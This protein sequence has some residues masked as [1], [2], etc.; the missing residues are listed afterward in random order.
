MP[1]SYPAS[2]LHGLFDMRRVL[3]FTFTNGPS[4]CLGRNT[5]VRLCFSQGRGRSPSNGNGTPMFTSTKVLT[6]L[7][8]AVFFLQMRFPSITKAGWKV[9][10]VA[11]CLIFDTQMQKQKRLCFE[12]SL[13]DGA[14]HCRCL[15][16]LHCRCVRL[17]EPALVLG[18]SQTQLRV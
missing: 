16:G 5:P 15:R 10:R 18:T 13:T 6:A 3:F 17:E 8:V 7:N 2:L 1:S 4:S 12:E 9:G 11:Q 14:I